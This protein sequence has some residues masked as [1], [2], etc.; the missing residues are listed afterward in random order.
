MISRVGLTKTVCTA[1]LPLVFTSSCLIGSSPPGAGN[2][3]SCQLFSFQTS[4]QTVNFLNLKKI[5]DFSPIRNLL[6]SLMD[7]FEVRM[8][9]LSPSLFSSLV[10]LPRVLP[11]DVLQW[12]GLLSI[13]CLLRDGSRKKNPLN[14]IYDFLRRGEATLYEDVCVRLMV[15]SFCFFLAY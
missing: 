12:I 14:M 1:L 2:V 3:I 6:P 10:S 15:T 11:Q 5:R 13:L 9:R 8:G 7:L 4:L